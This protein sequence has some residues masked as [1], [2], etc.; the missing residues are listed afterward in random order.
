M[1]INLKYCDGSGGGVPLLEAVPEKGVFIEGKLLGGVL[2]YK[3]DGTPSSTRLTLNMILDGCLDD[4][5]ELLVALPDGSKKAPQ[6][7]E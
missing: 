4:D 3:I 5:E 2:G 6:A 7:Q 1:G